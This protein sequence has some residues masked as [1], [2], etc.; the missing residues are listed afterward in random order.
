MFCAL[1]P[2]QSLGDVFSALT[3]A[4]GAADK[5]LELMNRQPEVSAGG[6]LV[7]ATFEGRIELRDVVFSYPARP[8]I[9][10]SAW[11]GCQHLLPGI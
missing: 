6:I 8:H 5:V 7:P 2:A 11:S 3:G 9:E 4:V 10:V 1:P